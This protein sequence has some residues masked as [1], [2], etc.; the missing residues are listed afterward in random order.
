MVYNNKKW[1][2]L[3]I[4]FLFLIFV[5]LIVSNYS[6]YDKNPIISHE[7]N[8]IQ[9]PFLE[10]NNLLNLWM[11]DEVISWFENKW[12]DNLSRDE[13]IKLVSAYMWK[14]NYFYM[15]EEYSK[16]AL[17]VL[18]T[19][20]NDYSVLYYKGYAKEIVKDYTWSLLNYD[21]WLLLTNLDKKQKAVLL[22]QKWHLLDLQ[23]NLE[24]AFINFDEAYK[25]DKTNSDVLTNLWRYYA[26]IWDNKK[27]FI[28]FK[29]VLDKDLSVPEKAELYFT[30]SSLELEIWWLTPDIDKSI[31]YSKRAIETYPAYPMWYIALARWLYMKNDSLLAD[32]IKENL[33]K[34]IELTPNSY[35]SYEL[36]GL[37]EYDNWNIESFLEM[38]EKAESVID[39]D[40]IL[41][42]SQREVEKFFINFKYYV[43]SEINNNRDDTEWLFE[44]INSLL[45]IPS[46][47][48]IIVQ[49]MRRKDYW[50]LWFLS[51]EEK[52]KVLISDLNN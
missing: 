17:D 20:K 39:D 36:F 10:V 8:E 27:A 7:T 28:Y 24:N 47:K 30:L 6:K 40:M 19:M 43:L 50:I 15:E 9:D 51:W 26:R 38:F 52:F 12:I 11:Y 34:A 45:D 42:D 4:S 41:M 14:W 3:V 32:K 33:D 48:A 46:W 22:N 1:V 21:E 44:F 35:Y 29:Q 49:Q 16:K 25:E 23:W 2:L 31:E 37:Y 5:L 13:K 18:S